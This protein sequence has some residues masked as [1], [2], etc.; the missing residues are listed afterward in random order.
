MNNESI[1]PEVTYTQSRDVVYRQVAGESLLVPI[2]SRLADMDYVYALDEVSEFI[3]QRLTD[4]A[5]AEALTAALC[6]EFEV[7]NDVAAGDV[8]RLLDELVAADLIDS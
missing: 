3:W 2:R 4:G 1:S 5:S 6:R 8:R 7:E